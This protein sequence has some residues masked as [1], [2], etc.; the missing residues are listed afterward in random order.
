MQWP[1]KAERYTAVNEFAGM[2][3]RSGLATRENASSLRI[4]GLS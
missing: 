2:A 4:G 3:G 1:I